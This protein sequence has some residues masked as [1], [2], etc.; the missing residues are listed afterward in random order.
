MVRKQLIGK[1]FVSTNKIISQS[2]KFEHLS[3]KNDRAIVSNVTNMILLLI[4][5]SLS[6]RV[7]RAE[8]RTHGVCVALWNVPIN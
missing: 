5:H 1:D 2:P 3:W 8:W 7:S 6:S 4:R